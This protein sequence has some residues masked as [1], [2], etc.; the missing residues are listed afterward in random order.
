M[1]YILCS[2]KVLL[3]YPGRNSASDAGSETGSLSDFG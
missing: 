3:G 1:A 2:F